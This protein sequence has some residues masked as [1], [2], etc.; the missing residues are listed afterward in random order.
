MIEGLDAIFEGTCQPGVSELRDL[1]TEVL[2]GCDAKGRLVNQQGLHRSRVYRLCFEIEGVSR[3][4]IAKRFDRQ[5]AKREQMVIWRWLPAL[6]L[7]RIG[8]TLIGVAAQSAGL[9]V[10]HL[11]EDLGEC[12][13]EQDRH[14]RRGNSAVKGA[15]APY[16]LG[17]SVS[18]QGI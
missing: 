8:P 14:A 6:G 16:S 1:L 3:C 2:G 5:R 18:I 7:G 13:L 9:C 4:L 10:W 12:M 17:T 11:Y 15:D